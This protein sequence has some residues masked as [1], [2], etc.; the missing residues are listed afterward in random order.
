MRPG[1]ACM[2]RIPVLSG[3]AI[4]EGTPRVYRT[5]FRRRMQRSAKASHR[6]WRLS[7]GDRLG[8]EGRQRGTSLY[9]LCGRG[10]EIALPAGKGAVRRPARLTQGGEM[11]SVVAAQGVPLGQVACRSVCPARPR[12]SPSGRDSRLTHA[13]LGGRRGCLA[14]GKGRDLLEHHAR[15]LEPM[16]SLHVQEV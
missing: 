13:G 11:N 5:A 4:G 8:D 9:R 6:L 7:L 16:G 14:R 10:T 12:A 15:E 3:S 2:T 1:L